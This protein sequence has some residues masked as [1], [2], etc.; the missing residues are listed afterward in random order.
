[1]EVAFAL[2]FFT[3]EGDGVEVDLAAL[4]GEVR[5]EVHHSL[6]FKVFGGDGDD[7]V[8]ANL[9]VFVSNQRV[10][11]HAVGD[12]LGFAG[13]LFDVARIVELVAQTEVHLA[14]HIL[15]VD[16]VLRQS[17]PLGQEHRCQ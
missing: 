3:N 17:W 1:M 7:D 8:E 5:S 16:D 9:A 2:D 11:V 13:H 15:V 12:L 10:G 4:V 14:V 6:L